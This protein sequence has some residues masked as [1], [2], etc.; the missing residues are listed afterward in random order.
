MT[1]VGMTMVGVTMMD[2]PVLVTVPG[3]IVAVRHAPAYAAG[4]RRYTI[5]E[6]T[7]SS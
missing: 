7:V 5:T 6:P 4:G 3:M 1:M 2:M